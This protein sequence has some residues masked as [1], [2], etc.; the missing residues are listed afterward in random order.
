MKSWIVLVLICIAVALGFMACSSGGGN[1]AL[2]SNQ[3][4]TG[5]FVDSPVANLGYRT[6][7]QSGRTGTN[8]EYLYL[9]GET[10]TFSIGAIEFPSVPAGSVITPMDI[11]SSA[12]TTDTRV[13][14]LTR[15]LL[16]LDA[17]GNPDNGITIS[18]AAY[19]AATST[20]NFAS[21]SFD[22]DVASLV[23]NGGGSATLVTPTSAASHLNYNPHALGTTWAYLATEITPTGTSTFTLSKLI[24]QASSTAYSITITA[25]NVTTDYFVQDLVLMPDGAWGEAAYHYFDANNNALPRY[26]NYSPAWAVWPSSFSTGY[27]ETGTSTG[28]HE[29]GT[30]TFSYDIHVIGFEFVTVPAGTFYALK[31]SATGNASGNNSYTDNLWI[32]NGIGVVKTQDSDNFKLELQSFTNGESSSAPTSVL[33]PAY[34]PGVSSNCTWTYQWTLKSSPTQVSPF[35]LAS[36]STVTVNYLSGALSGRLIATP[37]GGSFIEYNDGTT[38]KILGFTDGVTPTYITTDCNMTSPHPG[39]SYGTV[40]NG[41]IKDQAASYYVTD[42]TTPNCSGPD[43]SQKIL[44]TVQDVTVHG[45]LYHNAILHWYLDLGESFKKADYSQ[46]TSMGIISPTSTQTGGKSLTALDIYAPGIGVVASAEIEAFSGALQNLAEMT[47][48]VCN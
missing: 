31:I 29:T 12:S 19:T 45:V 46:F 42:G 1:E 15:L 32:V 47:S 20:I 36:G 21:L 16:T 3:T 48:Y 5:R 30:I 25:P 35:S 2:S 24:T 10:V 8:G 33:F 37:Q 18:N 14:N 44:F 9:P 11:F 22:A 17:D 13:V 23:A 41:M 28:T 38:F 27:H 34:Q 6:A 4:L 39:Y 40:Y 26:D 43:N 7:S